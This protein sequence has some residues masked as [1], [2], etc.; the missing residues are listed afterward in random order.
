[1]NWWNGQQLFELVS[2]LDIALNIYLKQTSNQAIN[3][4]QGNQ[5]QERGWYIIPY[6]SSLAEGYI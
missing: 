4:V 5:K 6:T 1:M 3:T 2:V